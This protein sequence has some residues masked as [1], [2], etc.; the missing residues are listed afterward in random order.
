M[1]IILFSRPDI[2]ISVPEVSAVISS[3][4]ENG[5]AYTINSCFAAKI[6]AEAG[7]HIPDNM[8]YT[9]ASEVATEDSIM[10]SYGGDGTFLEAV[11]QLEGEEIPILGLNFG[12]LGFLANVPKNEIKHAFSELRQGRFTKMKRTLVKAEGDFDPR[13]QYPYALNELA[14]QRECLS[15][16]SVEVAVNGEYLATYRGDGVLLSTPTGSTAYSLSLG[17][18]IV[19]PD[20][21]CFVLSPIAPHN[22]TMRPILIPD[23]IEIV[24][25]LGTRE[26][27]SFVS[28]DNLSFRSLDG[29]VFKVRK[30]EKSIFLVNLQNISF[31][32]T[33]RN[34][35]MWG[36][37]GRDEDQIN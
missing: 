29:A 9:R 34:K 25:K 31:Y 32:D 8:R 35:M 16:I 17:G 37:D 5:L 6:S 15:M 3:L 33:L 4:E 12:H 10:V 11:R 30:A 2:A 18:P 13:P 14:L 20:C 22:L 19:A 1:K 7:I 27:S 23:T 28:L 24:F 21:D 26:G 36:R